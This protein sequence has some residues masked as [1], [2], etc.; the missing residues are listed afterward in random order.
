MEETIV[1]SLDNVRLT[2]KRRDGNTTR[3]VD[4]IIQQL[5][6]GKTV[7]CH[8]HHEHGKHKMCNSELFERTMKRLSNEIF[9]SDKLN[10]F[11]DIDK[12]SLNIK[13]KIKT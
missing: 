6:D 8:D 9:K 5:F 1:S 3:I 13:L 7:L 2:S 10:N 4:N 12:S 11:L